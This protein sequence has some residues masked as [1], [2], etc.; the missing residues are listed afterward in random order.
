MAWI[1]CTADSK[2]KRP[3]RQSIIYKIKFCNSVCRL[4]T[5]WRLGEERADFVHHEG[6]DGGFA[7]NE[8]LDR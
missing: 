6:M 4:L 2:Q 7:V 3:I 8:I 5:L 1:C